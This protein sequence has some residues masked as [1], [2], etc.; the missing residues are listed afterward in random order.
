MLKTI[1]KITYCNK[2]RLNGELVTIE[3]ISE[4]YEGCREAEL[5]IWEQYERQKAKL[6]EESLTFERCKSVCRQIAKILGA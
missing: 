5:N 3:Q 1:E 4:I 2:F 6:L